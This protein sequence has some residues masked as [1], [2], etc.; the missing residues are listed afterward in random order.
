VIDNG[1]PAEAAPRVEPGTWRYGELRVMHGHGNL[2]YGRAN[3]LVLGELR[4]DVHV[5]MNPDVEVE[6][7]AVSAAISA[8]AS[9]PGIGL[10]APAVY[11]ARGER[12]YLCKRYPS[13]WVLFLRGFAPAFLRRRFKQ[14]I[15]RYEMRDAI[16]ERFV[17]DIPLASGCFMAIRTPLFVR[18]AGFDADYFMYFEDYDLSVRLARHAALAYAP[19]ARI[20]HHGG[21]ASAR[22][23]GTCA[24][25]WNRRGASSPDTGGRSPSLCGARFPRASHGRGAPVR[26]ARLPVTTTSRFSEWKRRSPSGSSAC[27]PITY[28]PGMRAG[29][30]SRKR[31]A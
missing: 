13:V 24:G 8:L 1:A 22:A 27:A 20:V 19:E 28:F 14:A 6:P 12:Q 21:G 5:V 30:R 10:V 26:I 15:D 4:S 23:G 29:P 7:E 11:D 25:S 18:V 2:G 17:E 9:H 16:A 31:N 3:N